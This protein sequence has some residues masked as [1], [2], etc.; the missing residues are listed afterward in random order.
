VDVGV[1]MTQVI[2]RRLRF[3]NEDSEQI[4]AL[5]ANHMRFKDVEQMRGFDA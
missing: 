2:A 1:R 3:S 4:V 5:V